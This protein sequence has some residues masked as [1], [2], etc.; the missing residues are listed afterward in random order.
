MIVIALV[1][2]GTAV[3]DQDAFEAAVVRLPHG[4]V[5]ADIGGDAGE[6][7]ILDAAQPQDQFKIGGVETALAGLVDDGLARQRCQVGNDL[8]PGLA[9]D[10]HASARAGVAD[11][12]ADL[13]R[14]PA[15]VRG[16]VREI[17]AVALTGMNDVET[18]RAHH[19]EQPLDRLDR[20]ARQ[21]QVVSHLV[22]VAADAAEIGLHVDD[23][24]RGVLRPQIAVIRPCIGLGLQIALGH[25]L[26]LVCRCRFIG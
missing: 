17:G 7:D 14:S 6:D 13:P 20:G 1:G 16:Q 23:D 22:D 4:G 21:R 18:L 26:S 5:D 12:G 19:G 24:E 11:A 3:L 10:Q 2:G 15:F 9:T 25:G 8:P